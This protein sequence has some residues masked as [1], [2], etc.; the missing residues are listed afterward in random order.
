M[1]PADLVYYPDSRPGITRVRHG[2]GFTYR[3]P[4]GT[5]IARGPERR[6]LEAMAVPPA[7]E[8][9]WL[10]PKPNGHLLATG[11]DARSRKQYR[12][13]PDW[14]KERAQT[15]YDELA[16]FGRALPVIRRRVARDLEEEPGDRT[17]AL[18]ATL[19]LIDK[20]A[21]RVGNRSYAEE[22][23]SYGAVTLRRRHLRLGEGEM[24]IAFTSKGGKK[25]RRRVTD[26]RLMKALA[27]ARD[28]P[29]ADL[30]TW[31][32][33]AG[34]AHGVTSQ[35]LN[36]YL[37]EAAGQEGVTAKV[38]RTWTGTLA[39]FRLVQAGEAVTIKAMSEAA[40]ER[41]QNTPT[42][43]RSSYI[44][45]AVID[46]AGLEN[47][48]LPPPERLPGLAAGEGALLAFLDRQ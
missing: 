1:V 30:I 33:D 15:K 34:E 2:R 32:D 12:Y 39:A 13:H 41:L 37:A 44:H 19:A 48:K 45:P 35:G 31:L 23:G 8:N 4:D 28:L 40:A 9:V 21:L 14:A 43:A 11:Y 16:D 29:G 10:T 17:F 22:N 38:F 18:A 26:R 47:P 6:R 24:R 27:T 36:E 7:Y 20:L 3:A 25:V 42:I 46:L 5:T